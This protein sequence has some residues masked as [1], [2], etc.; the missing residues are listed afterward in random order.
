MAASRPRGL[1]RLSTEGSAAAEQIHLR[2]I[3]I[4]M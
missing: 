2:P 1:L 4:A 3:Y